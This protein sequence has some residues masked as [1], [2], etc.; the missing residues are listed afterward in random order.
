MNL[1]ASLHRLKEQEL[2]MLAKEVHV[3][4]TGSFRKDD[5]IER[6]VGMARIRALQPESDVRSDNIGTISYLTKDTKG[7]LHSLRS[8]A[9]V[10][11]WEKKLAGVLMDFTFEYGRDK[12][13]DMEN[14]KAYKSLKAYKFF[15]MGL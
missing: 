2:K 8:F 15:M 13:F 6:M 5:I 11:E 4:L 10:T 3:C 1:K 14:L 7:I 12:R 9:S